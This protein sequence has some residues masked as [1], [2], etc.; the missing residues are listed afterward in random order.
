M[1][2]LTLSVLL[3]LALNPLSSFAA[4][5]YYFGQVQFL[6]PN[7]KTPYGKSVSLVK[8]EVLP[9]EGKIV[10]TITEPLNDPD[11]RYEERVIVFTQRGQSSSFDAS[12]VGGGLTGEMNFTGDD[13][14]WE[15]ATFSFNRVTGEEVTGTVVFNPTEMEISKQFSRENV[16][17]L[18]A[19]GIL[20]RISELNYWNYR[21]KM[22]E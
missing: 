17:I 10:E 21:Q 16:V 5:E 6:G 8:R 18:N 11:A 1:K 19:Q 20:K 22:I 7:G 14:A 13:W 15:Q 9:A 4:T 12:E 2:K 3:A